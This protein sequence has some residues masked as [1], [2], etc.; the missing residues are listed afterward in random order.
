VWKQQVMYSLAVWT[1]LF[2]VWILWLGGRVLLPDCRVPG[3]LWD[4]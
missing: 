1:M 3:E 4:L 2:P